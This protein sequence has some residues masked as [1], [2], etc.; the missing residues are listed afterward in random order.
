MATL[1]ADPYLGLVSFQKGIDAGILDLTPVRNI[2]DL[3]SHFDVPAPGVKRLTYVRMSE[4][5]RTA[6]ALLSCVMNGEVEGYPC[7]AI[8][9]AVSKDF[10]NQGLAKQ[11]FLD[12]IQDQLTQAKRVGHKIIYIE[13]VIDTTNAASQHV[14]QAVLGV[15]PEDI[16]DSASGCPAKRYTASYDTT[17]RV[18]R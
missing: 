4:D 11:I 17:N 5:L 6:I 9:Y 1:M 12:V 7:I 18:Q 10:R 14:A 8:G 3:Y 15:D 2:A 16:I 13:A